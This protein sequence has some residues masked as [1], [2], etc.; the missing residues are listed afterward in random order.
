M[1]ACLCSRKILILMNRYYSLAC[2]KGGIPHSSKT[3]AS[4]LYSDEPNTL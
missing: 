3:F 1:I 2:N 4:L